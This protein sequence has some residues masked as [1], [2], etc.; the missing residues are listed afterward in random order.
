MISGGNDLSA[1]GNGYLQAGT[2][3]ASIGAAFAAAFWVYTLEADD[4]AF[5]SPPGWASA[6]VTAVGLMLIAGG[7][8]ATSRA[9]A[10]GATSQKQVGG[11]NSNNYQA[12]GNIT[13]GDGRDR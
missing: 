2:A 11:K 9:D 7:L 6:A 4:A 12:G 5:W 13:L 8:L 3:I 10:P 1:R